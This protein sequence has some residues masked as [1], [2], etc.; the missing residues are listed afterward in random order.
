MSLWEEDDAA[1]K[2]EGD[3]E[4]ECLLAK[5]LEA[6]DDK[7]HMSNC[8]N[9]DGLEACSW[10]VPCSAPANMPELP[11]S[12][13][14]PV[15]IQAAIHPPSRGNDVSTSSILKTEFPPTLELAFDPVNAAYPNAADQVAFEEVNSYGELFW[16]PALTCNEMPTEP[17]TTAATTSARRARVRLPVDPETAQDLTPQS[18]R[19][20]KAMNEAL[21][22]ADRIEFGDERAGH[23]SLGSGNILSFIVRHDVWVKL[24][25][26]VSAQRRR[27]QATLVPFNDKAM[28]RLLHEN[29][30]KAKRIGFKAK[31]CPGSNVE[32]SYD[33]QRHLKHGGRSQRG[34]KSFAT[35]P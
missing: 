19:V 29:G 35:N 11:P 3:K 20:L 7:Y 24:L 2:T 32:I 14:D 33:R 4:S 30:F 13:L 27:R 1:C 12:A 5:D 9:L 18:K 10:A 26:D 31:R 28:H 22:N 15:S 21:V 17:A 23:L 8:L 6:G 34:G 16:P 25:H